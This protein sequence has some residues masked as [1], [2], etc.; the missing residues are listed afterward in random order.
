MQLHYYY[1]LLLFLICLSLKIGEASI[2]IQL[3]IMILGQG[4]TD[5]L[6]FISADTDTGR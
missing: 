4:A 2:F 3:L 5:K 1:I 6:F